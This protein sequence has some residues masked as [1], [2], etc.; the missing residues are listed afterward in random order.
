MVSMGSILTVPGEVGTDLTVGIDSTDGTM[1][2]IAHLDLILTT[3]YIVH[4]IILDLTH[5]E[6]LAVSVVLDLAE[7]LEVRLFTVHHLSMEVILTI[8]SI[9]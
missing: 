8:P 1:D 5:S 3:P 4:F 7:D 9:M 2:S 6:D